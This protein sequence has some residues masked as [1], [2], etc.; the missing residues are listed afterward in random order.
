M[1]YASIKAQALYEAPTKTT[2]Q[3]PVFVIGLSSN[4]S[5][6]TMKIKALPCPYNRCTYFT[7]FDAYPDHENDEKESKITI[8]RMISCDSIHFSDLKLIH[9]R[10]LR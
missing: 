7:Y 4:I 9:L 6:Q 2:V 1:L 10:H 5:K 3:E 8:F